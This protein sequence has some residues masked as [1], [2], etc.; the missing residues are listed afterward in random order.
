MGSFESKNCKG[1]HN[2]T[3]YVGKRKGE[4]EQETRMLIYGKHY[5]L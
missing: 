2:V 4:K 5:L 3:L 1:K